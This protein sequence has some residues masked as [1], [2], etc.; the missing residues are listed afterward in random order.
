MIIG[1]NIG[2]GAVAK[3]HKWNY[4]FAHIKIMTYQD[5]LEQGK[6]IIKNVEGN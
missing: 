3:L 5:I 6:A 2:G 4:Q 1:S